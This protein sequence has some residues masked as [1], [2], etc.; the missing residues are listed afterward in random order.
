MH[1]KKAEKKYWLSLLKD[2]KYLNEVEADSI[3]SDCGELLKIIGAIIKTVKA[4][5]NS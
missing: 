2:C 3:I 5:L 4:K 1:L